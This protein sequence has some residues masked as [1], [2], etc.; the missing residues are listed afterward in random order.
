MVSIS[1]LAVCILSA[2]HL[3]PADL[4]RGRLTAA[5]PGT[6][7]DTGADQLQRPPAIGARSPQPCHAIESALVHVGSL[8]R[9]LFVAASN[10]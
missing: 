10:A 3:R 9:T 7:D 8:P 4:R 1:I 5:E 2:G 6:R